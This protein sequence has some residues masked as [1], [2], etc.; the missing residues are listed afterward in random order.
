MSLALAAASLPVLIWA[1][2]LAVLALLSYRSAAVATV[3]APTTRFAV[4]VPAHDEEAGIVATV[5]SLLTTD[6]PGDRRQVIVVADNCEDA[7]AARAAEAGSPPISK[8]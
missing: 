7:T 1:A 6:Y 5:K 4:V 2:Y 8:P 3:G